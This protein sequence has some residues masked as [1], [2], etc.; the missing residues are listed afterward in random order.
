MDTLINPLRHFWRQLLRLIAR[1]PLSARLLL[2]LAGLV[3][4]VPARAVLPEGVRAALARAQ[5]DSDSTYVW[6]APV[7]SDTPRL[8]HQAERLAHPASVMKLVTTAAALHRLGPA[9]QWSTPVYLDGPIQQG[10]LQGSLYLQGRGDP[11]LV[12]ERVWL[13]VQRLRALGLQEI[14]GDIV[15]DRSHYALPAQA[16]GAFDG[17]PF[18]P[19]NVQPDALM[20]NQKSLILWLRPD[21]AQGVAW[22]QP[23]PALAGVEVTASVPL[24]RQGCG[25]YR[26]QLAPDLSQPRR[27]RLNGSF[28]Q[29]CGEKAWPLAYQEPSSYDARLLESLW[30][31]AGGRLVGRVRDGRVPLGLAP[32]LEFPSPPLPEVLR[33][34]NK[35]SNN[36][37]AQQVLLAL[38]PVLPARFETARPVLLDWLQQPVGCAADE[39]VLDNGSGLSREERISARCLARVMQWSWAQAW[40]PELLAS[41]PVAGL[42]GTARRAV[43][44]SGRAHFKTGSLANV[45]ALA[46]W[47]HLPNGRRVVL[48]AMINHPQATGPEVRAALDSLVRWVVD[49]KELN[50]P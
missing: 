48:V 1:Q 26:A 14:R 12:L 50:T 41:L 20:L 25:D 43:S 29:A 39:I 5:I 2:L 40:M 7:G 37:I 36:M 49:D 45:A 9:H 15:L 31:A 17:E 35:Y 19:Y 4:L 18:R 42:D 46:G 27:I 47:I 28:P 10:V 38:S 22:V 13:L 44:A 16:P 23:E 3:W 21:P 33:D 11:R 30:K 8:A 6:V 34:M 32:T 24:N